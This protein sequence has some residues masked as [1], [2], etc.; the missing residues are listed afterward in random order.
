MSVK[1]IKMK[2]G[3]G[4]RRPRSRKRPKKPAAKGFECTVHYTGMSV[5]KVVR[6]LGPK[7]KADKDAYLDRMKH[8]TSIAKVDVRVL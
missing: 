8:D 1:R 4:Y 6:F 2:D 7:A 5:K 3:P